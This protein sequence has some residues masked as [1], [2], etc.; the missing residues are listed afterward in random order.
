[1]AISRKN[2]KKG[3]GFIVAI[4]ML[5]LLAFMGL[6]LMQSSS[7]EYSQTSLSVYRT[8]GRQ[9]AEAVADEA[10]V[11]IEEQFREKKKNGIFESLI[12]Q[13]ATSKPMSLIKVQLRRI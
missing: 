1:M 12:S 7:A 2:N 8:M 10:A 6:F 13:A 9:I 11:I 4:G 5:G 3:F